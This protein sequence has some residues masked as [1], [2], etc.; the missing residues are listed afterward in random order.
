VIKRFQEKRKIV[1]EVERIIR[2]VEISLDVLVK[3]KKSLIKSSEKRLSTCGEDIFCRLRF[4]TE[5]YVEEFY[6]L[7]TL[8]RSIKM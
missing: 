2:H 4:K 5:N 3:K 1:M 7:S 6:V 8:R